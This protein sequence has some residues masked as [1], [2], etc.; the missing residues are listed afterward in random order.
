MQPLDCANPAVIALKIALA[1]DEPNI[2]IPCRKSVLVGPPDNVSALGLLGRITRKMGRSHKYDRQRGLSGAD[3]LKKPLM[4]AF[5]LVS[6]IRIVGVIHDE[7][8]HLEAAYV[9]R[10]RLLAVSPAGEAEIDIIR[11]KGSRNH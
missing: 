2:P 10:D 9:L 8:A 3:G 11:V 1:V 4:R 5:K 6:V 7:Y